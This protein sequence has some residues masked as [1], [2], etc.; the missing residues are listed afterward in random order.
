V[1]RATEHDDREYSGPWFWK[2]D[3][4][5]KHGLPPALKYAWDLAEKAWEDNCKQE[6]SG[7]IK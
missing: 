3:Y 7:E 5:K 6:S 2:T 4:C 1:A